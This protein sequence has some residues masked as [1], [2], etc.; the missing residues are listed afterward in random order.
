MQNKIKRFSIVIIAIAVAVLIVLGFVYLGKKSSGPLTDM[1]NTLGN[2][3]TDAENQWLLSQRKPER[4]KK[5]S[6]FI[7]NRN[8]KKWMQN[9]D[10]ILLGVYDNNY[11]KSFQPVLQLGNLLNYSLPLIQIYNA[12][13]DKPE[14]EF[15]MLY[16]KAIYELGSTPMITWEPW[17]NDFNREEHGLSNAADPNKK[18][19][20]AIARGDYDFYIKE[21]A[22]QA[23]E[24]GHLLFIR[25]GHE[26]ND[27]YRYP[28][29]PQNNTP[30]EYIAAWKH[31]VNIFEKAGV[32]NIL[33]VWSPHPAYLHYKEYFPG[34]DYV[35]WV[36]VGALNYGNAAT[37]SKW[38]SFKD[39]FG[40]YYPELATFNK[41]LMIT[42]MGSLETGGSRTQWFKK[43]FT[44]TPK[45]YPQL[46][47]MLFFDDNSDNTTLNKTLNWS[48]ANDTATCKAIHNAIKN[49]WK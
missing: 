47:A 38:W 45:K 13:G 5:L 27:P 24:F 3:V 14:E 33:W 48:I 42:E 22:S 9:P 43:A 35:D 18:G 49:T 41:P 12:W 10:T 2:K 29:G 11:K 6:W 19:M 21:W 4:E 20:R 26:M 15:P 17:L 30:Q 39:I 37:W 36:G 46:K 25:F 23:H 7:K 8:Y 16:V 34:K 40:R 28:W 1:L 44:D 32:N 31:I